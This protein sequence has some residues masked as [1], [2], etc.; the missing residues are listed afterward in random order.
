MRACWPIS[1]RCR[2]FIDLSHCN[3]FGLTAEEASPHTVID[4]RE[5]VEE[6]IAGAP[7]AA[8]TAVA[9]EIMPEQ[10]IEG[11]EGPAQSQMP[12]HIDI[13]ALITKALTAAGLMK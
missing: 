5:T 3:L 11:R 8:G 7:L 9:S 12:N 10:E 13:G 1:A 6:T 4:V 2:Y